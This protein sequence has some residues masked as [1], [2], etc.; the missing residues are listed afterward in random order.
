VLKRAYFKR[1]YFVTVIDGVFCVGRACD[2]QSQDEFQ[3]P[4]FTEVRLWAVI[5]LQA[6]W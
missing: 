6:L 4:H 3:S 2:K 1:A 5:T